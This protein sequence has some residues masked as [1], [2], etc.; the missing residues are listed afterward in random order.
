MGSIMCFHSSL[1]PAPWSRTS[2][3]ISICS[4]RY[5]NIT[6]LKIRLINT[7]PPVPYFEQ[8]LC[9]IPIPHYGPGWHRAHCGYRNT[10]NVGVCLLIHYTYSHVE[11]FFCTQVCIQSCHQLRTYSCPCTIGICLRNAMLCNT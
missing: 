3:E 1:Q 6:S 4:F 7:I 11:H 10:D 2:A 8:L 9:F 5:V